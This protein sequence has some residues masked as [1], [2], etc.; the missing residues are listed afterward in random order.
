MTEAP[1][2]ERLNTAHLRDYSQLRRSATDR[3]IAGVAGGLGRHLNVDPTVLRVLFVV[4]A[5]FGGA[6]LLL[7]GALW[8][9][10]PDERN[11]RAVITTSAGT[12]N[13]VILVAAV[14]AGTLLV[15]D[16]WGGLGFPWPILVIGL[17]LF[18]VL[19]NRDKAMSSDHP[20]PSRVGATGG[21]PDD[22]SETASYGTADYGTGPAYDTGSAYETGPGETTTSMA[23]PPYSGT[24]P[25]APSTYPP[26]PPPAPKPYRGPKLFWF[27]VALL[28]VALGTLGLYDVAQGGVAD[29]AYPAIALAV[30]GAM[31]VVGAWFGRPGGLTI[32]G[33]VAAL[34]LVGTSVA[35]P[36]FTGDRNLHETPTTAVQVQDRYFVPA[37]EVYLDLRNI[38]DVEDLD[39]RTVDLEANAGHLVVVL[40]D[41]V[42]A[43]VDAHVAGAGDISLPDA[44]RS[45]VGGISVNRTID[46]GVDVP[47][48]DLNLDLVVGSIEVRQ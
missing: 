8:L 10:V 7:Y 35:E 13:V 21:S 28:A 45:G 25:P 4:L 31:L 15:G 43:Q 22:A 37:G 39:G 41:G 36:R 17:I 19:T 23:E 42:D 20:A 27:T 9:F 32:L 11:D 33:V 5:L 24:V 16:S 44:G 3:K 2:Q 47:E 30:I 48:I 14:L 1:Q 12:R 34:T 6:G 40:P 38:S 29:A 46:G 18:L 26:P